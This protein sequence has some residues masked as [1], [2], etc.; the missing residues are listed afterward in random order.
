[1]LR[2]L[3]SF[4]VFNYDMFVQ[5]KI[6]VDKSL[7]NLTKEHLDDLR[8]PVILLCSHTVVDLNNGL[9]NLALLTR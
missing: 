3:L 4:D 6:V 7:L 2:G 5:L 1:M 8:H 9:R